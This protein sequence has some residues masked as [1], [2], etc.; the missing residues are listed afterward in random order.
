MTIQTHTAI[1]KLLDDEPKSLGCSHLTTT[2]VTCDQGLVEGTDFQIDR[3]LGHIRRLKPFERQLFIFHCEYDDRS[4]I[5]TAEQAKETAAESAKVDFRNLP[6]WATYTPAEAAAVVHTVL[7][8]MTRAELDVWV[9]ANVSN[10]AQART[11][12]KLMGDNLIELRNY[13]EVI[14]KA[15]EMLRIISVR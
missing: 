14:A 13:C 15:I 4:E 12:L 1:L 2:V 3:V 9:D 10:I 7:N 8:G 11:A 6:A 5:W